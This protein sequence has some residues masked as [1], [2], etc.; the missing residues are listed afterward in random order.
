[1]GEKSLNLNGIKPFFPIWFDSVFTS[2]S[3]KTGK[4]QYINKKQKNILIISRREVC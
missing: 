4:F 2:K 3:I 1:M